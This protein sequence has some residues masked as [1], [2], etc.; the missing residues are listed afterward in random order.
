M[1]PAGFMTGVP[2]VAAP[3]ARF[4]ALEV[5][6][7]LRATLR[8]RAI[9]AMVRVVAVIDVAIEIAASVIP[10][11]RADEDATVVPV[12]PVVSVRGAV[13]GRVVEVSVGADRCHTDADVDAA[14]ANTDAEGDLG[15]SCGDGRAQEGDG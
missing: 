3:I 2:Y 10:R 8:H 6:E 14:A 4:I 11:P 12:G 5:I 15:R 13:I 7:L 1:F 9:V